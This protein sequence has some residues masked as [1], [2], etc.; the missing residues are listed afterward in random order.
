MMILIYISQPFIFIQNFSPSNLIRNLTHETNNFTAL[1]NSVIIM[2]SEAIVLIIIDEH[3][4]NFHIEDNKVGAST[5]IG[6]PRKQ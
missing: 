5:I 4:G 3:N 2:F 6:L 1:L